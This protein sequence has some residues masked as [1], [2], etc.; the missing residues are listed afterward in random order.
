VNIPEKVKAERPRGSDWR[1]E[2]IR[3]DFIDR[4]EGLDKQLG[5]MPVDPDWAHQMKQAFKYV[6]SRRCD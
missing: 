6:E 1:W 5:F 2:N 3:K 4:I